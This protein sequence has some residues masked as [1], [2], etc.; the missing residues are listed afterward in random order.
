MNKLQQAA[1]LGQ[2]IWLDHLDRPLIHSG[3]L[4]TL[5]DRGLRG[6]TSNPSIF[7]KAITGGEAYDEDI[8]QLAA[9]GK[10]E[11]EIYEKLAIDD[12]Q[13]AAD[14][15]LPVYTE[16]R[17]QDGF[18]SLEANPE[19]AYD[20]EKTIEE[21]RHL[22]TAVNRPNVM[23]KVPAT[24]AGLPAITTLTS[25]GINI[26]VTLM[27]SLQDYDNVTEA[28]LRGLEERVMRGGAID[29][30]ASVA[31]FFVSRVDTAVDKQ[32]DQ[33]NANGETPQMLKGKIGIANAKMAYTRYLNV[34]SS[35][36]WQRLA[37]RGAQPQRILYGSTSVKNPD[38]PQTMYVDNLMG[39]STVNTLPL[40]TIKTFEE[41]G[42]VSP[43]LTSYLEAAR[44][45]LVQLAH[46]GIDLDRITQQLQDDGVTKFADAF[47]DLMTAL[48]RHPEVHHA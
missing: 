26:N 30:I 31:S 20:T 23:I 45:Q 41:Q 8:T 28:Y 17:G 40:K 44:G 43:A 13:H 36:R 42:T 5:I 27:F 22:H 35:K 11:H 29:E 33:L 37:A 7:E 18:I 48:Q 39:P 3:D 15:L 46:L 14:L 16:A 6:I 32:L 38:Y 24:A 12:I 21:V 47:T 10:T 2:S 34:F 19:L 25:E 1:D 4:Q 9:A